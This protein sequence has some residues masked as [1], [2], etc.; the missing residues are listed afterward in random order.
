MYSFTGNTS[1]KTFDYFNN[2][3]ERFRKIRSV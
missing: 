1:R 3:T 2:S